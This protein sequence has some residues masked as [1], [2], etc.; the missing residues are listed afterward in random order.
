M[1]K[2]HP[3]S[4]LALKSTKPEVLIYT[5]MV[6]TKAVYMR[7]VTQVNPAWINEQN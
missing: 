1:C 7:Y 4:V 3:S 2:I 6:L 5:E